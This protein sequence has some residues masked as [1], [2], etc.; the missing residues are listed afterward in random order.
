M[1]KKKS[2]SVQKLAKEQKDKEP[3]KWSSKAV[4]IAMTHVNPKYAAGKAMLSSNDHQQAGQYCVDLHNFCINNHKA[5]DSI[6]VE[7]R[8]QHFLHTYDIFLVSF[9]DLYDFF[10]LNMLDV[11]LIHC[12]AL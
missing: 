3:L 10:N 2:K 4:A 1:S 6:M 7:Y 11:S 5:L 12:F 8:K 9:R